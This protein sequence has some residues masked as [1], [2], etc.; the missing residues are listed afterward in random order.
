MESAIFTII[1]GA[2]A[3]VMPVLLGVLS[4]VREPKWIL[5][6]KLAPYWKKINLLSIALGIGFAILAWFIYSPFGVE[7]QALA[8]LLVSLMAFCLTQMSFTDFSQRYADRRVLNTSNLVAFAVGGS[9]IWMALGQTI[10]LVYMIML[11]AATVVIFIPNIGAS[12]GRALQLV[13]LGSVPLV[14]LV[15]FQ[16]GLM[17][18]MVTLLLYGIGNAIYEKSWK[19]LVGKRS[20]PL[21]PLIIFPFLFAA[22]FFAVVPV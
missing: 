9:F 16:W 20:L 22:L 1:S 5:E 7:V 18:F 6:G 3:V 4:I 15:G 13:V 12:D 14:G 2:L 21:V 11:L 10:F 17:F 8:A 19:A